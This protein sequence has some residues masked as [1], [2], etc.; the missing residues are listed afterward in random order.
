MIKIDIDI[1]IYIYICIYCFVTCSSQLIHKRNHITIYTISRDLRFCKIGFKALNKKKLYNLLICRKE[2]NTATVI[3]LKDFERKVLI[4]AW[5]EREWRGL[6]FN[7]FVSLNFIQKS[8]QK[9]YTY[10]CMH[11]AQ[12]PLFFSD[13][14]SSLEMRLGLSNQ[15]RLEALEGK[16]L[17]PLSRWHMFSR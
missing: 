17:R 15:N 11:V 16:S 1:Y 13:P 10:L 8:W 3:S 12:C 14:R 6:W 2:L 5:G 4:G 9:F 7:A